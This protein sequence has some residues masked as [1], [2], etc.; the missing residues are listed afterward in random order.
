MNL[1]F[2][3]SIGKF[4]TT[5]RQGTHVVLTLSLLLVLPQA[6]SQS[7]GTRTSLSVTKGDAKTTLAVTVKDPTGAAVSEGT[8]SFISGGQS[9][10]SAFAN[11]NGTATLT[12]DR[13]PPTNQITAVYSGSERYAASASASA[14][15]QADATSGLPDFS[16]SANPTSLNVTAGGFGTSV[17]TVTPINGFIQS[18]TLSLSGLPTATSYTFTPNIVTPLTGQTGVSTLQIQTTAPTGAMNQGQPFGDNIGH[19]AY[20]ALIPGVL[21]L[22]GIGALGKR[23]S[24]RIVGFV[25]LMAASTTGLMGCSQRYHYLNRPPSVAPGTPAGSYNVTVTAYSNN[26]GQVTTHTL[27]IALAVK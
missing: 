18:V 15:L 7:I 19:L 4:T 2:R 12:L 24:L 21:A 5:V 13:V 25:L 1:Q 23:G 26:G 11:E 20:A 16:I 27:Q 10:G 22:V 6:Y 17:I 8:V 9:V 3:A 14:S